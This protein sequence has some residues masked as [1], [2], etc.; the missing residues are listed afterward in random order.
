ILRRMRNHE[1]LGELLQPAS[2]R[3]FQHDDIGDLKVRPQ[4]MA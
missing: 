3:V 1:A 2:V 4:A